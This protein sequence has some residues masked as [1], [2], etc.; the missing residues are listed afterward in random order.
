MNSAW[1]WIGLVL[2]LWAGTTIA[3]EESEGH[4]VWYGECYDDGASNKFNCYTN[5]TAQN[6]TDKDSLEYLKQTCPFLVD[7]EAKY[8]TLCCDGPMLVSMQEKLSVAEG[9]LKRCPTCLNNFR[10][11]LCGMTCDPH[12]SR[13]MEPASTKI[14][15]ETQKEY[16]DKL[17]VYLSK[18]YMEGTFNSCRQVLMPSSGVPALEAMCGSFGAAG[19]TYDRWFAYMGD[20]DTPLVPF[21]IVYNETAPDGMELYNPDVLPCNQSYENDY[22]CSCADCEESCPADITVID[23]GETNEEFKIGEADGVLVIMAIIYGIFAIGFLTSVIFVSQSDTGGS[24]PSLIYKLFFGGI[25]LFQTT[26]SKLFRKLGL[27]FA[28]YP[29]ATICLTS[30]AVVGMSYGALSLIVTTDRIELWASP[31]S[32]SRIEKDY[33]DTHFGP[34]YR[35]E[36]VFIKA[37]GLDNIMYESGMQPVEFGPVFNKTF[38]LTVL[39]LQQQIIQIG[40]GE[41]YELKNICNAPLATGEVKTEDCLVQSIWGYLK[42]NASL[43][44]DDSYLSILLTCMQNNVD[45]SCLGPYG[46]PIFAGLALGGFPEDANVNY[47]KYALSTGLSLTFL[48]NNHL[49]KTDLQPALEWESKFIQFLK[50]WSETKMPSFMSIAFSAERSIEDELARESQAEIATVVISYAVMFLYITLAI[51]RY[52]SSKTILIDGKFTLGVSGIIIVLMSV[53]SSLG[54]FG[55]AGVATTL[56]TIEVIPFLVLAIGVDNIFILVQTHQRNPRQKT[57]SHEEH[58]ARTLGTVGPSMLLTSLS[59]TCCFLIGALSNMPAVNTFALYASVATIL[60]FIFQIT[61]FVSI[62]TLDD[63]RQSENRYDICCCVKSEKAVD[64]TPSEDFLY[65]LFKSYYSKFLLNRFVKIVVVLLFSFWLCSSLVLI[66][67]IEAG[68][69]Q[70]IAVPTDSYVRSYFEYMKDVLSMGPNVYFVVKSGLNYSNE[71]VQNLF[72]GGLNCYADSLT[73]QITRASKLPDRSYITTSASSWLDDYF[74][75]INSGNCCQDDKGT[76]CS[77]TPRPTPKDFETYLPQFLLANPSQECAKGGH[78]AYAEG[79]NYVLNKDGLAIAMDSYFMTYHTVLRTSEEYT[80]ALRSAR[81]IASSITTM[82][83]SYLRPTVNVT[84]ENDTDSTNWFEVDND[85]YISNVSNVEVFP[86]SVFYVFYEQYLTITGDTINSI[87]YSL[88]AVFI[89]SFILM[90]FNI[91]S[92]VIILIMVTIIV[93][94]LAAFMVWWDVPLNAV[95]L[96]NLVVGVGIAVE[97]C[98]HIIR[99]YTVSTLSGSNKRAADALTKIGSSVLSGITLTKIVGIFVLAFAK[100]EIFQVFYFRMYLGIVLIGA[101]HGLIFLPVLL[102]YIGPNKNTNPTIDD[103]TRST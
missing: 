67:R 7:Q 44:E 38:L 36:Q 84:T 10:K 71:N 3:Q 47:S 102:S 53:L 55:Y 22:A 17:I 54:I 5:I 97:F 99:A 88:S 80:N 27:V 39:D 35:T 2:L 16:I 65:L 19:C 95:S 75:W 78:A 37:H 13:F 28:S 94:N 86:Y 101:A 8:A 48:V 83:Q 92:S 60:N 50:E 73:T 72:C 40:A 70:E 4:C 64:D 26:L 66:P 76:E 90:G 68:L 91:F 43:L 77:E 103:I 30:W 14:N 59:E 87:G 23:T 21:P 100:T 85:T 18:D 6:L 74:D 63:K 69:D 24:P 15:E 49:D 46:G 34:F 29:G 89:V 58:V 12:Q 11:H 42:N 25:P 98:S 1:Q 32:Q 20:D 56:L 51:G 62:M 9:L 96:V 79:L 93:T 57:E 31:T 33:F 52:R 41:S 81:E 61:C 45:F 82:L